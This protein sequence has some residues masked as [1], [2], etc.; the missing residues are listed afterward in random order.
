MIK[1]VRVVGVCLA[2][3]APL[4][5]VGPAAQADVRNEAARP[6]TCGR[7][8][9]AGYGPIGGH[10][11]RT[12]KGQC[13]HISLPKKPAIGVRWEVADFSSGQACV[14]VRGYRW[15]DGKAYWVSAGC[16]K[17]GGVTVHWGKD[18]R[19]AS[20]VTAVKVKSQ[21]IVTGVPVY[22]TD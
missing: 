10:W 19:G 14:K 11:S 4:L 16:G 22:F 12:Y 9:R 7:V 5:I 18:G 1:H 8:D 6:L 15:R 13:A 2:S 3:I 17:S 20:G 21:N